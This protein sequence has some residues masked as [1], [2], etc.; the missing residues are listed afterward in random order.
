V[1]G[2]DEA[3]CECGDLIFVQFDLIAHRFGFDDRT[4][5]GARLFYWDRNLP[6]GC[7]LAFGTAIGE[8]PAR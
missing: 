6:R 8:E 3:R 5:N 2:L 1:F 7:R 4:L